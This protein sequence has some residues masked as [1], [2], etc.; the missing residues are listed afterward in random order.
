VTKSKNVHKNHV[1]F[2]L[3]QSADRDA[4]PLQS[5][6]FLQSILT[7]TEL[8]L[9]ESTRL[10]L[11]AKFSQLLKSKYGC[12]SLSAF[13]VFNKGN[14][15]KINSFDFGGAK[16]PQLLDDAEK[17]LENQMSAQVFDGKDAGNLI[18]QIKY[19][20][21]TLE[22]VYL[23][24]D[25]GCEI[26]CLWNRSNESHCSTDTGLS[27][28]ARQIQNEFRWHEK[29]E[30]SQSKIFLDELTGLYNYRFLDKEIDSELKRAD[31][32]QYEFSLVF[33]D[34][35]EF[36]PIND[37]YGHL[38]G[39]KILKK[40]G[41]ILTNLLREVDSIFR[42]GGDEFVVM[43]LGADCSSAVQVAERIREAVAECDF[44]LD[45]GESVQLTVSVGVSTYPTHG[46]T[47]EALLQ[48]ADKSMY[49]S[50]E[51]GKNQVFAADEFETLVLKSI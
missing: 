13:R 32:F 38:A 37:R 25:A 28:L 5:T 48:L 8:I 11:I 23:G 4:D 9:N 24:K 43:L 31:R 16:L 18:Q 51:C 27:Y 39:N 12:K 40:V 19:Q 44:D 45:H 7:E 29:L 21:E 26:V 20:D 2:K 1:N 35:D 46:T 49:K 36:K 10:G 30:E 41:F 33:I 50:K 42:Y 14:H 6:D 22:Y 17:A 15:F 3:E 47:K 34:L